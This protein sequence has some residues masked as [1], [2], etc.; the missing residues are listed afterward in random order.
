M[1]LE[2]TKKSIILYIQQRNVS[3]LFGRV[4]TVFD[5]DVRWRGKREREREKKKGRERGGGVF[6]SLTPVH[7]LFVV[8]FFNLKVIV[9]RR[10]E[11]ESKR[12]QRD[13]FLFCNEAKLFAW[14]SH[15]LFDGSL[16]I[17]A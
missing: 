16:A 10:G 6:L 9:Q 8:F 7:V 4:E 14:S 13:W 11:R 17:M 12:R 3:L 15:N 1:N 5:R 2:Y